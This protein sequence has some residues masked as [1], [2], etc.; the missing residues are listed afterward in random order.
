M[1]S[2]LVPYL[3]KPVNKSNIKLNLCGNKKLDA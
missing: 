1:C 3:Y 2:F